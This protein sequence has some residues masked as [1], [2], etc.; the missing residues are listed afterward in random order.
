MNKT[1]TLVASFALAFAASAQAGTVTMTVTDKDGKPVPDAVVVVTP[2]VRTTPKKPLPATLTINQEKMQF[3]PAVTLAPVGAR[4]VFVNNDPW[5]HHIRGSAAGFAQFAAGDTGGF[6]LRLDGKADGK[7]GKQ[8]EV[9]LEKPG[10]VLL[11]CHL[12]SSMRGHV[13]VT[14]SP[15]S[16]KTSADGTAIFDDVPDGAASIRIWHADQLLDLPV[17]AVTVNATPVKAVAQLQVVP[18]RRR[19]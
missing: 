19:I 8:A 7:T 12:H 3:V 17:Q 18:R 5:E 2:A 13:Y 11:G 14:D 9:Q 15:W 16:A 4:V 6:E 10:A 1:L